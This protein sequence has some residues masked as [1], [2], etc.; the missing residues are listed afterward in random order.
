MEEKHF[1]IGIDE[2]SAPH[3]G[4][5]MT[6]VVLQHPGEALVFHLASLGMSP[7]DEMRFSAFAKL[8]RNVRILVYD[9]VQLLKEL[10]DAWGIVET[11]QW[12]TPRLL[13]SMLLSFLPAE[14]E[15]VICLEANMLCIGQL[16]QL[17]QMNM[18]NAVLAAVYYDDA[19]EAKCRRQLCLKTGHYFHSHCLLIQRYGWWAH[20]ITRR[21]QGLCRGRQQ[22]S[23]LP[24]Q[25]AL[26]V[27]LAGE[28]GV[29]RELPSCYN[30]QCGASELQ[31]TA[32]TDGDA[33]LHI[34]HE[35]GPGYYGAGET[36]EELWQSCKAS[37]LWYDFP[38]RELKKRAV[39]A[40]AS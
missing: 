36:I 33:L 5:L 22:R 14:V 39:S 1:A 28:A 37:S 20:H 8:Y 21:M 23:L 29:V 34:V 4:I 15:R 3:A 40:D 30:R 24:V 38:E 9:A 32:L 19:E 17:W 26:N 16:D 11:E 13:W 27:L 25:D 6:S 7:T 31:L 2:N 18:G 12:E 35:D 10:P